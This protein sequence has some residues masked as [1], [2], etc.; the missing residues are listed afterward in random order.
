[1]NET[2]FHDAPA[3]IEDTVIVQAVDLHMYDAFLAGKAE[4]AV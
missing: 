1:M 3:Q 4:G 2:P